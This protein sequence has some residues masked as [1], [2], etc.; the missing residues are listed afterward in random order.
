M[1]AVIRQVTPLLGFEPT[2]RFSGPIDTLVPGA[3]LHEI[4]AVVPKQSPIPQNTPK[5]PG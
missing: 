4:E 3:V 1:L 5:R 2:I